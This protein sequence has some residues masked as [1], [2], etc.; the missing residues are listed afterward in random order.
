MVEKNRNPDV[1][2]WSKG[3]DRYFNAADDIFKF[4]S[5]LGA[6]PLYTA[7]MGPGPPKNDDILK[8]TPA[9]LK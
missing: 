2:K 1:F 3:Y 6:R 5:F 4:S 8:I 7:Y 9:A